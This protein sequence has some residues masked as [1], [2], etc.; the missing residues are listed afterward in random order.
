MGAKWENGYF[1][2]PKSPDYKQKL[3]YWLYLHNDAALPPDQVPL[4]I[5]NPG[6]PCWSS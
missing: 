1:K 2:F 5:T 3:Q 6:G 4:I